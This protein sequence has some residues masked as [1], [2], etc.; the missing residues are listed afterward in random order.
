MLIENIKKSYNNY[1]NPNKRKALSIVFPWLKNTIMLIHRTV[2]KIHRFFDDSY[3]LSTQDKLMPYIVKRHK[4]V[5]M[6]KL[7]STDMKLQQNKKI[8]LSLAWKTITK[9]I[10]H[11]WKKRS[12]R[13]H[14]WL[15]T[16]QKWYKDGILLYQGKVVSGV[17]WGICQMANML[18]WLV[19]HSPLQVSQHYHH[20]YDVFPDSGRILPFGSGATVVYNYVDL[21]FYNPTDQIFQF[22]IIQD[23][24]FLHGILRSNCEQEYSYK[25]SENNHTFV[26]AK[27]IYYRYNEL[28]RKKINK[29]TWKI[30]DNIIIR[31]NFAPV[32]YELSDD[33]KENAIIIN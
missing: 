18:Y 25:I 5:L 22:E 2:K 7:W 9:S 10:L 20:S 27:K 17:G 32:L 31:K 16:Y 4:S 13:Q 33:K 24:D 1:I 19:L 30:I 29:K 11:P 21:E 23:D 26:S 28:Y 6:R 8:N 12:F 3:D 14:I 15:P